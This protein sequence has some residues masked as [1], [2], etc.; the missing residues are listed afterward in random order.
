MRRPR[1]SRTTENTGCAS[2][3]T[4]SPFCEQTMPSES[5]RNGMSS[6]TTMMHGVRGRKSILRRVRIEHAH[7]RPARPAQPSERQRARAR[8]PRG[9]HRRAGPGPVPRRRDRRTARGGPRRPARR[10]LRARRA[11][12][13][14]RSMIACRAAGILPS[15]QRFLVSP[16]A[17]GPLHSGRWRGGANYT[18]ESPAGPSSQER[19]CSRPSSRSN[20]ACSAGLSSPSSRRS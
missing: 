4:A 10:C 17:P 8:R 2:R 9:P 5:T 20:C 6:V 3:C 18:R 1:R 7:L 11:L 19:F 14:M 15:K 12:A 13:A 16:D